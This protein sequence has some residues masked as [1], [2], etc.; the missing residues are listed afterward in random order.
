M[1]EGKPVLVTGAGGFVGTKLCNQLVEDGYDVRGTDLNTADTTNLDDEV[2]FVA[3]DLTEAD[4]IAE[5]VEDIEVVFHTAAL[6]S[7]SSQLDWSLFEKVNVDGTENLCDAAVD[8]GVERIVH[9]S[10]SGVY[11]TPRDELLPV[12]EDH[13]KNPKSNYDL[14]KWLQEKTVMRAHEEH[15]VDVKAIRPVPIY[16]PGSAYAA[17]QVF[18]MI[19]RGWLP[20]YPLFVDYKF[21]LVHV[22]D[23]VRAAVYLENHGE[24]GEAYNVVDH[25]DYT[26]NQ[27]IRYTAGLTGQNVVGLPVGERAYTSLSNLDV[28]VPFVERAFEAAGLDPIVE[29]DSLFYLKGNYWVDNQ[30]LVDTGFEFEYPDYRE[31]VRETIDWFREE[32]MID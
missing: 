4:E 9:W 10:T 21:A 1:S 18:L 7:Y 12:T 19:A 29:K 6:F 31:G 14:S 20:A 8:E 5:A 3:A 11:G 16:G 17:G 32:G 2:E 22:V 24:A 27:V 30:K 25:Q 28:V 15:G 13:P 23:I 26:M